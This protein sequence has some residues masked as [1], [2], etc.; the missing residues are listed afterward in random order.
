G[1]SLR[2][3][4]CGFRGLVQGLCSLVLRQQSPLIHRGDFT[5][6]TP[7]HRFYLLTVLVDGSR[8][9]VVVSGDLIELSPDRFDYVADVPLRAAS[10]RQR[11]CPQHDRHYYMWFHSSQDLPDLRSNPSSGAA[12]SRHR[13]NRWIGRERNLPGN[14]RYLDGTY[15]G[16]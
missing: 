15:G 9:L 3:D 4:V 6:G 2:S 11:R 13:P 8:V 12:G 10:I 16:L 5:V 14:H 1:P 7:L